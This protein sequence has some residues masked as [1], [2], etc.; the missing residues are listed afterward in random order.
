VT[1]VSDDL[2]RADDPTGLGAGWLIRSGAMGLASGMAYPVGTAQW[3]YATPTTVMATN[4]A[5]VSVTLGPADGAIDHFLLFVGA[6]T[7]GECV[8]A[9][10]YQGNAYFWHQYGWSSYTNIQG[11]SYLPQAPG[12]TI[13]LRRNGTVHT[14]LKNGVDTGISINYAVIPIDSSHLLLGFGLYSESQPRYRTI[15]AFSAKD[16]AVSAALAS[17]GTLSATVRPSYTVPANLGSTGQLQIAV[18]TT[19]GEEPPDGGG[20]GGGWTTEPNPPPPTRMYGPGWATPSTVG[21]LQKPP[22]S[23]WHALLQR[24]TRLRAEG[25]LQMSMLVFIGKP[26]PMSGNGSLTGVV[27]PRSFRT[28]SITAGGVLVGEGWPLKTIPVAL[29]SSGLLDFGGINEGLHGTIQVGYASRLNGE[30]TLGTTV[31]GGNP[32]Y[33]DG[34]TGVVIGRYVIPGI[35]ASTGALTAF[36]TKLDA[37][38]TYLSAQGFLTASTTQIYPLVAGLAASGQLSATTFFAYQKLVDLIGTGTLSATAFAAYLRSLGVSGAGTLTA[39]LVASY[40]GASSAGGT[41]SVTA[42]V[43]QVYSPAPALA[44]EGT[45]TAAARPFFDGLWGEVR[46][47]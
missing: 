41:G 10:F 35:F 19:V 5:E 16:T 20:G 6:N 27:A 7:T 29:T 39:L 3:A 47:L 1:F 43:S 2:N 24:V 38:F 23:G 45:L 33:D 32:N 26:A 12:D 13:T 46:K 9:Y 44:A 36:A 21:L 4:D 14:I 15:D 11:A 18:T 37:A 25:T 40:Q 31:E 8:F 17:T 22:G 34:L 42:T 30:G 28:V